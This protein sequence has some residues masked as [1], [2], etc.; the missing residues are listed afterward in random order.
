[1]ELFLDSGAYSAWTKGVT[2]D[3]EKYA[4]FILANKGAF[5]VVANLD[6]IPG[7]PGRIP[8]SAEIE[9]A[10]E[11]G[12]ENWLTLTK[13]LCP[14]GIVPLHTYHRG[15]N[16]RWLKRLMGEADYFGIG[17]L[18]LKI[19]TSA[20][21]AYLDEIMPLLTDE[22]GWPIRKLHGFGLTS[23]S[24]MRRYPWW[25]VDSSSWSYG[26]YGHCYVM[27]G[28]KM[29][30]LTFG[31]RA[32][33]KLV[34]G[35]HTTNFSALEQVALRRYVEAKGFT[36]AELAG[37]RLKRDV[38][39]ILAFSD[40]EA[41]WV[42]RPFHR[43]GLARSFFSSVVAPSSAGSRENGIRIYLAGGKLD[44]LLRHAHRSLVSFVKAGELRKMLDA[45]P[46]V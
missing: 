21:R 20:K 19:G 13:M 22:A 1:M 15:E 43:G 16:I 39:N 27:L 32:A 46:K 26:R 5:A 37:D 9:K 42:V 4:A 6:V 31:A 2:V 23:L 12:W 7:G 44:V 28:E 33:S 40:L 36:I 25:S 10:A 30:M 35:A 8:S 17:G 29:T 11:E 14:A 24:M 34:R 3:L 41:G 18:A 45:L 38:F